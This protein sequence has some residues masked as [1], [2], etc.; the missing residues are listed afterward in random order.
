MVVNSVGKRGLSE[1]KVAQYT[2][3]KNIK[4]CDVLVYSKL[5]YSI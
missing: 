5:V 3:F 4:Q 2:K 1:E